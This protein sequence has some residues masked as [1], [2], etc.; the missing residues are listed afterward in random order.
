M[1]CTLDVLIVDDEHLLGES[2]EQY[3]VNHALSAR[4]TTKVQDAISIVK[5]QHPKVA[6]VD[7]FLPEL[8]GLDLAEEIFH[9]NPDCKIILMSGIYNFNEQQLQ[10]LGVHDFIK[11]PIDFSRLEEIL[12]KHN[13]I[14]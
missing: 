3:F 11:K 1:A 14:N 9:Y 6:L 4:H 5:K 8:D 13:V 7:I 10:Q 2:I 12:K